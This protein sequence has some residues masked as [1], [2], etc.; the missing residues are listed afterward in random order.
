MN[1]HENKKRRRDRAGLLARVSTQSVVFLVAF[2]LVGVAIVTPRPTMPHVVPLP[3]IDVALQESTERAHRQRAERARQSGLSREARIVGEEFRRVVLPLANAETTS[4]EAWEELQRDARQLA[5]LDK[6]AAL[7]LRA[8][9]TELF[10]QAA[11]RFERTGRPD[12]DLL[13][14]G[15][16]FASIAQTSWLDDEG[17]LLQSDD[18]LRLFFRIHWG[19]LTGL[20]G[21]AGFSLG[22]AELRRYYASN[23]RHPYIPGGRDDLQGR[24][25]AR[26]SLARALG[27]V[28][29]SYP[30]AFAEG[31]FLLQAQQPAAAALA[32]RAFLTKRGDGPW[33]HA[34]KNHLRLAILTSDDSG[35]V[36]IDP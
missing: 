6:E 12:R 11:R 29:P 23:L 27:R 36:P 9:Q 4:T 3:T 21:E 18:E 2:A 16:Q 31:V 26:L 19:K 5:N 8:L 17:Q 28:D 7:A 13:E 10:L 14:L 20:T 33:V 22:L 15:G 30:A 32:F 24:A 34:A 25:L 35:I 1:G